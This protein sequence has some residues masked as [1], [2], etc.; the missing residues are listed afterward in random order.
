MSGLLCPS[1]TVSLRKQDDLVN[2]VLQV[3]MFTLVFG[4]LRKKEEDERPDNTKLTDY[5]LVLGK[6]NERCRRR[7]VHC[8]WKTG[9]MDRYITD[10]YIVKNRKV[11]PIAIRSTISQT[12]HKFPHS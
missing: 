7:D 8:N 4:G 6:K 12:Y 3:D 2:A 10:G 1:R 5:H 11:H 9:I